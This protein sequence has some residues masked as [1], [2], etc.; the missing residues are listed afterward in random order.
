F[1]SIT[2]ISQ[3]ETSDRTA[4]F[5]QVDL[6]E[7]AADVVELFDAAAEENGSRLELV[8]DRGVLVAGERE[9]LF[10]AIGNLVDNAIKHGRQQGHVTVQVSRQNDE[11]IVSVA[12]D[13]PGIPAPERNNVFK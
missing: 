5:R 13:G 1:A 11:A 7:I 3:I 9:L 10:D 12:D 4:A 6:S 2:R 8:T